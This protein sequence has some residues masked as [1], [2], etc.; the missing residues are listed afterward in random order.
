M[1]TLHSKNIAL[2]FALSAH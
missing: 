2:Q 1:Q